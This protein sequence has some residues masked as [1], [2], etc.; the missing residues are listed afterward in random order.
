MTTAPK[1][2]APRATAQDAA[3]LNAR[4]IT[5][6]ANAYGLLL[7]VWLGLV[8]F[9]AIFTD[10]SMWRP[11]LLVGLLI[12]LSFRKVVAWVR[13]KPSAVSEREMR[14]AYLDAVNMSYDDSPEEQP[15]AVA[16]A[17]VYR[18]A[19]SATPSA[20]VAL[21]GGGLRIAWSRS[22]TGT[23]FDNVVD[24][25]P[26]DIQKMRWR[27]PRRVLRLR[28]SVR[29]VRP[30]W[31]TRPEE[32]F[33][34]GTRSLADP[35]TWPWTEDHELGPTVELTLAS[36]TSVKFTVMA[37]EWAHRSSDGGD[38]ATS[39]GYWAEDAIRILGWL[40]ANWPRPDGS[41]RARAVASNPST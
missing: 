23:T 12:P 34:G 20:A 17:Q 26:G 25:H 1:Q 22:M 40:R 32:D 33:M 24:V 5:G 15:A 4:K 30:G 13:T 16:M 11:V 27:M 36:G 28:P 18:N 8:T 7:V 2:Q 35:D 14:S 37:R 3:R 6:M 41:R 38:A 39:R 31:F 21:V 10:R 19:I 29:E 9:V